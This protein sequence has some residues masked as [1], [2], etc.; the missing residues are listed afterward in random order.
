MVAQTRKD[1]Y[2]IKDKMLKSFV[3]GDY[4]TLKIQRSDLPVAEDKG[5][6]G[7]TS[8][9]SSSL[10]TP[11]KEVLAVD[12]ESLS[13]QAAIMKKI[14]AEKA[15]MKTPE[16]SSVRKPKSA[17]KQNAYFNVDGEEV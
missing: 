8:P 14:V 2:F 3:N 15:S 4:M 7:L 9:T 10:R 6:N 17:A 12:D 16:P 13:D 1:L 11:H 5:V